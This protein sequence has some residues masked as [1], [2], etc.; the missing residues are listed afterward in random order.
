[1]NF[2]IDLKSILNFFAKFSFK[3]AFFIGI[4]IYRFILLDRN[5]EISITITNILLTISIIFFY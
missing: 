4:V 1:M 5:S 3:I 2:N